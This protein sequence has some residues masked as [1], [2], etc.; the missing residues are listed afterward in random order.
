MAGMEDL[1][2][3]ALKFANL[4]GKMPMD[5]LMVNL[6]KSIQVNTLTQ[7]RNNLTKRIEELAE[8]GD[9]FADDSMNPFSILG[10]TTAST[11]DEVNKAYKKKAAKAHPDKETGTNEEMMKVNAAYEAIRRFKG[12]S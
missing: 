4:G 7:L 10:V 6:I 8:D 1:L 2:G 5:K 3:D 12:W 11:E 9:M